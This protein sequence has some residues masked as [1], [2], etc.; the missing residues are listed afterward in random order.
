MSYRPSTSSAQGFAVALV[1]AIV[2]NIA[3]IEN[4]AAGEREDRTRELLFTQRDYYNHGNEIGDLSL[5]LG[6]YA[7]D[8]VR[9]SPTGT[10]RGIDEI[11]AFFNSVLKTWKAKVVYKNGVVQGDS[12]ALQFT[13]VATHRALG[14]TIEMDMAAFVTFNDEAKRTSHHVY[15]DA[16]KMSRYM[17]EIK[18]EARQ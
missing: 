13:W 7:D 10:Q 11:T 9:V 6:M 4:S 14:K 16:A 2:C 17:E 5:Y 1:V 3:V 15:F 8:A 18:G 12:M